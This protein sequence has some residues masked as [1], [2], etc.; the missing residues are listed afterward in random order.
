MLTSA[1]NGTGV[2]EA[3]ALIVRSARSQSS[4]ARQDGSRHASMANPRIA[5]VARLTSSTAASPAD[6]STVTHQ[7]PVFLPI[8]VPADRCA[9]LLPFCGESCSRL[10]KLASNQNPQEEAMTTT[11]VGP[12]VAFASQVVDSERSGGAVQANDTAA[13]PYCRRQMRA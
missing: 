13:A 12:I 5:K 1:V 9:S 3:F 6:A 2:E 10:M 4:T 7:R 8:T 11:R